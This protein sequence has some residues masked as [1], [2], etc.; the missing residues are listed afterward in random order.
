[1]EVTVE[2]FYWETQRVCGD[3]G[4]GYVA[5]IKRNATYE[6][7]RRMPIRRCRLPLNG[8]IVKRN[9]FA[10]LSGHHHRRVGTA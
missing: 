7:P 1:M 4:S 6:I 8:F 9:G 3:D 10:M 2:Q 5:L